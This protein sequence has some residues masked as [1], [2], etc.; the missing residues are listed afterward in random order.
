MRI[1][2][3]VCDIEVDDERGGFYRQDHGPAYEVLICSRCE[4]PTLQTYM[5][6]EGMDDDDPALTT[7]YP[8]PVAR[9][10]SLPPAVQQE[11]DAAMAVSQ[12][13]PNAYAVLLGRVMDS[14][15]A[16]R[17]AAGD[18][19]QKRLADLADRN[20]IPKNLA[21]MAQNIRGFRNVAAHADVGSITAS[22][23]PFLE[24]LANAVL[25]YL[26]EAPRTVERAQERLNALRSHR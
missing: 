8:Q 26:Y 14:V 24:S 3:A 2:G 25:E 9:L 7:L 15:C 22:E 18:T 6:Y 1:A 17:G 20:E 11:Y 13:S 19:L 21:D 16:E 5:Y 12:I 4:R 10:Q 23:I